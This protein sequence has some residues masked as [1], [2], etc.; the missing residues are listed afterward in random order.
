MI[1]LI[2]TSQ[3][4]RYTVEINSTKEYTIELL[5]YYNDILIRDFERVVKSLQHEGDLSQEDRIILNTIGVLGKLVKNR[6]DD[7]I[8]HIERDI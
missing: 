6:T 4:A 2:N 1:F 7:L 8:E 3:K 5:K